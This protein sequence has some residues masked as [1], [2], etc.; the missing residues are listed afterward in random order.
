MFQTTNQQWLFYFSPSSTYNWNCD[1]QVDSFRCFRCFRGFTP[2]K[3]WDQTMLMSRANKKHHC[4]L[5]ITFFPHATAS[6]Q[7]CLKP[8][9]RGHPACWGSSSRGDNWLSGTASF[10]S[11]S[12]GCT[13]L[14]HSHHSLIPACGQHSEASLI[15]KIC[16]AK[17]HL[18]LNQLLLAIHSQMCTAPL[19]HSHVSCFGWSRP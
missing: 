4:T 10:V 5:Y 14:H 11:P 15:G 6:T 8:Y 2:P 19:F 16:S 7:S 9:G 13:S 12:L 17:G 1:S 3:K 18:A